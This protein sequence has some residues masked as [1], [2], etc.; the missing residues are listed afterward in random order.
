MSILSKIKFKI[1]T[2][3]FFYSRQQINDPKYEG[4]IDEMVF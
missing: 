1:I 2:N 4:N 3:Y